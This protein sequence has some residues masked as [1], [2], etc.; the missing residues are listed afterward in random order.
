MKPIWEGS[1]PLHSA[2]PVPVC[3]LLLNDKKLVISNI[4]K[5]TH[6]MII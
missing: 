2:I 6:M 4:K 1:V 3:L 5:S